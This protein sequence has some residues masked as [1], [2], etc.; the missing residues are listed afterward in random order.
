MVICFFCKR[1]IRDEETKFNRLNLAAL[2]KQ[3]PEEMHMGD[4]IC[5]DCLFSDKREAEKPFKEPEKIPRRSLFGFGK[6]N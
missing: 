2:K 5:P 6:K 1:K 4:K 3:I